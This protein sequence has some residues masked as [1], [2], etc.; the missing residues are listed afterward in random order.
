MRILVIEDDEKIA[1]F[2]VKGFRQAGHEV[3]WAADGDTGFARLCEPGWQAAVVDIM[4]P[5]RDGLSLVRDA[6]MAGIAT[7][8]IFLSAKRELDDRI[9]GLQAGGDD[10]LVKPFAFSELLAR[11]QALVRRASGV[12]EP[13]RLAVGEL[14]M[15]LVKR[16]VTRAGREV[17]LQP[18]EF[19]LL[20][21]LLRHKGSVV[22]KIMLMEHVW[23]YSF[24]P[25]TSVVETTVSRLRN[26]LNEGFEA[27]PELIR[28]VRGVGY[29][30]GR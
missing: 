17:L 28:T 19:A 29:V 8:I 15:D 20:E 7:P 9:L 1:S 12:V 3:D 14:E 25:E 5:F 16:R 10:Y 18:R 11:V 13:V 27:Q 23:D 2:V 26:K 4:L 21:Y 22:S 24:D 6:R 30:L